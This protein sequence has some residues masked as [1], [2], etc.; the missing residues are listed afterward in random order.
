MFVLGFSRKTEPKRICIRIEKEI[1]NKDID[2]DDI[3]IQMEQVQ[4]SREREKLIDIE[5]LT[6]VIVELVKS[7]ICRVGSQTGDPGG[8]SQCCSSSAKALS[9]Q[10]SLFFKGGQSIYN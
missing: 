9:W 1:N 6:N 3:D 5:E 2:M 10:N 4:I 8:K 7:K